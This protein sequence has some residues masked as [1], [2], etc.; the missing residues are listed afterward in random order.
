MAT[1]LEYAGSFSDTRKLAQSA[2]KCYFLKIPKFY[3]KPNFA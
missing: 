2:T 3:S 1:V